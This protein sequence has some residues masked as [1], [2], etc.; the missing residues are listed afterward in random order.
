M[1][2]GDPHLQAGSP[3]CQNTV[4]LSLQVISDH[5]SAGSGL[6]EHGSVRRDRAHA[7]CTATRLVAACDAMWRPSS[8][9]R[10]SCMSETLWSSLCECFLTIARQWRCCQARIG[11][12]GP[13]TCYLHSYKASGCVGCNVATL[14]FM[15]GHLSVRDT[16]AL[17]ASV[18]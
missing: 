2:C 11:A 10:G 5:I 16:G 4:E 6:F 9:D 7:V 18:F 15:P 13:C 1:Q 14:I 3:V 12:S 8:L 17:S